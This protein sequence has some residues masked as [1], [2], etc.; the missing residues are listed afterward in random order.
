MTAPCLVDGS[1][2][3]IATKQA[4]DIRYE[5]QS[6]RS[7]LSGWG[8]MPQL[9]NLVVA[10]LQVVDVFNYIFPVAGLEHSEEPLPL[11]P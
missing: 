4:R 3:R 1:G 2:E 9:Y 11:F 5:C 10:E 6:G 8:C 7:E